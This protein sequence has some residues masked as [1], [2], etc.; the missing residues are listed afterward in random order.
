MPVAT[1]TYDNIPAW[2]RP[3]ETTQ[4]LDWAPLKEIDLQVFD[5]PGGKE[6]LAAELHDAVRNGAHYSLT[7][8][9]ATSDVFRSWLLGCNGPRN[10]GRGGL[11]AVL[12][13]CVNFFCMIWGLSLTSV[14][15]IQAMRFST[16]CVCSTGDKAA[17]Y[18][19]LCSL[20]RRNRSIRAISRSESASSA[21]VVAIPANSICS[22]FGYREPTRVIG[23]TGGLL[24][25]LG[26][27]AGIPTENSVTVK[28]NIEMLNIPKYTAN[29][30]YKDVPKH[31]II[32]VRIRLQYPLDIL[33]TYDHFPLLRPTRQRLRRS[34]ASCST[35]S[36]ANC[37]SCWPS[38]WS[39]PRTTFW[40]CVPGLISWQETHSGWIISQRHAYDAK[41]EDHLRYVR[42]LPLSGCDYSRFARWYITLEPWR[43]GS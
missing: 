41:S 26:I 19:F 21:P 3:A 42:V 36:F 9:R 39:C 12:D 37:S 35:T 20:L 1:S 8:S 22:Y 24:F 25:H 30:D 5:T 15:G 4:E 13:R 31:D 17:E 27:P 28:E 6:K 38:S 7:G 29:N 33:V 18:S 2:T 14:D 23:S 34:T 32:K 40:M 16:L 10:S 43:N 11:E